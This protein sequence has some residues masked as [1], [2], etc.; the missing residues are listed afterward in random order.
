MLLLGVGTQIGS[1]RGL[2]GSDEFRL[3]PGELWHR[4]PG[5]GDLEEIGHLGTEMR[6]GL[7]AGDG[8]IW[9]SLITR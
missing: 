4:C 3:G 5:G 2:V 9:R 1:W 7:R 6:K 8:D